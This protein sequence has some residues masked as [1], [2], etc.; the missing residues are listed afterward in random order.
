MDGA[1]VRADKSVVGVVFS[2]TEA[3]D[4]PRIGL[5]MYTMMTVLGLSLDVGG[6]AIVLRK[7][8]SASALLPG[9]ATFLALAAAKIVHLVT[10]SH[11]G[12]PGEWPGAAWLGLL[13]FGSLLSILAHF[14]L[15][16]LILALA[17][18]LSGR[19]PKVEAALATLLALP[20]FLVFYAMVFFGLW[21]AS[22]QVL[23]LVAVACLALIAV[24]MLRRFRTSVLGVAAA[25]AFLG[26][27]VTRG[28]GFL[29]SLLGKMAPELEVVGPLLGLIS[30]CIF[31]AFL[32]TAPTNPP[33]GAC[34]HSDP[35][36]LTFRLVFLLLVPF[37]LLHVWTVFELL[38]GGPVASRL[39]WAKIPLPLLMLCFCWA[40]A[41][42][43][44]VFLLLQQAAPGAAE[45]VETPGEEAARGRDSI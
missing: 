5:A 45:K 36:R 31:L 27:G 19:Q 30:G 29:L 40:C 18:P 42:G 6:L 9:T 26:I 12:F 10:P 32:A 28:T 16:G 35:L 13:S 14:S 4:F 11:R 43:P 25:L 24:A 38:T 17:G 33:L 8:W 34:Q 1:Q 3:H 39:T 41:A 21:A 44:A 2:A 15:L 20:G 23:N 37:L 22:Q 7:Y